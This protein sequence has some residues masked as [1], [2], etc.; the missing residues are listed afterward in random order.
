[1]RRPIY[2]FLT[3]EGRWA[4]YRG[5]MWH[6]LPRDERKIVYSETAAERLARIAPQPPAG[7]PAT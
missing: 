3:C 1:M 2:L 5:W 4:R 7:A 6:L